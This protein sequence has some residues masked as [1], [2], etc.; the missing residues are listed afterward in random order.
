MNNEGSSWDRSKG[1]DLM[2]HWS[3]G[4]GITQGGLQE[5]EF[6][7]PESIVKRLNAYS[8]DAVKAHNILCLKEKRGN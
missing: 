8:Q 1:R 3:C 5:K 4:P 6:H 7:T 2:G